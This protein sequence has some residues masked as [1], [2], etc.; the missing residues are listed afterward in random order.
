VRAG[1]GAQAAALGGHSPTRGFDAFALDASRSLPTALPY[2]TKE[3]EE[4]DMK[5]QRSYVRGPEG[6]ILELA[7]Q[8]K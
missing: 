2:G 1:L 4:C 8:I 7:E 5:V 3:S 6:I